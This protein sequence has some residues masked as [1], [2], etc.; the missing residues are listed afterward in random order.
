MKKKG[1][2]QREKRVS[3]PCQRNKGSEEKYC[4]RQVAASATV[5]SEERAR[6]P[7]EKKSKN[8]TTYYEKREVEKK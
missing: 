4:R 8:T 7:G 6:G 1:R 5:L 3:S 2:L